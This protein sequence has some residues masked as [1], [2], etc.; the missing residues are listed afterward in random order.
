MKRAEQEGLY[1]DGPQ[2]FAEVWERLVNWVR[3]KDLGI[4]GDLCRE[5]IEASGDRS[6]RSIFDTMLTMYG[7]LAGKPRVGEKTPSHTRYLKTLFEWFPDARVI[8]I[9]REPKAV[10]A[11]QLKTP[12]VK[13]EITPKSLRHGVFCRNRLNSVKSYADEWRQFYGEILPSWSDDPRVLRIKYE[14]LAADPD[15]VMRITCE[16]LGEEFE[17][18]MLADRSDNQTAV[19][20]GSMADKDHDKWRKEHNAKSARPVSASSLEKWR[21]ELTTLEVGVIEARCIEPMQ[22]SGYAIESSKIVRSIS[23]S[24]AKGS[25]RLGDI[26]NKAR[27]RIRRILS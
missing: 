21:D 18:S 22:A 17:P 11:S 15:G 10:V 9:Q 14:N 16:F 20:K 3:F 13:K 25:G 1:S 2:D 23:N 27:Y 8:A 24:F 5:R 19:P 4:D 12:W 7:E 6:F 26:E